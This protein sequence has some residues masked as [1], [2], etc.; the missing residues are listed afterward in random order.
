M[1]SSAP[2]GEQSMQVRLE[3]LSSWDV[4]HAIN[5]AITTFIAYA[6]TTSITPLLTHRPAQPVGILWA[7]ISAVF[8]FRDTREHS[9]S[10]GISRLFATCLSFALCQV[11]L[12]FFLASPFGMAVLIAI[13]ALL[14]TLMGRR[15]E[16]GL[17]AIT[18]TVVLVVAAENP[19]TAW[20][21][22]LLRLADTVAGVA[23]GIACKWTASFLFF[24][25]GGT[26]AD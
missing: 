23:V 15:D 14:A 6:L 19:Q 8:V 18:T 2:I 21:Q 16:I 26:R 12:L 20:Q 17:L 7:V 25:L 4:V 3:R 10:A 11:Y 13:G 1:G 24:R 22:P 9:L 5:L